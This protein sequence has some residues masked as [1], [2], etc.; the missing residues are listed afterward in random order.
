MNAPTLT[1]YRGHYPAITADGRIVVV[2]YATAAGFSKCIALLSE[3]RA[4][5]LGEKL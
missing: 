4:E 5:M 3:V 2:F 1:L